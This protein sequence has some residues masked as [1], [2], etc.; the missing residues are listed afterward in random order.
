MRVAEGVSELSIRTKDVQNEI[1]ACNFQH[2]AIVPMTHSQIEV[3]QDTSRRVN[4]RVGRNNVLIMP[5]YQ[6]T[7]NKYPST[8]LSWIDVEGR[9]IM[10]ALEYIH[11]QKFVHSD[12]KAM[13]VFV[14]HDGKWFLG[15][16]GSCT[17]FGQPVTSGRQHELES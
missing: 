17:R 5:W 11:S 8:C 10:S 4:C 14:S 1:D 13:N 9:R 6:A 3:D 12:V 2:D 7:L 16:F 15:D